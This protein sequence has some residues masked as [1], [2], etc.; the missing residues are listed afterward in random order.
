VHGAI[1]IALSLQKIDK[2]VVCIVVSAAVAVAVAIAIDIA[3]TIVV[4]ILVVS[5]N[6]QA[7]QSH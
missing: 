1:L 5:S 6:L 7:H 3:I 4:V 2:Q